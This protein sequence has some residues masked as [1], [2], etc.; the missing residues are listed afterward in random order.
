MT[1]LEALA[2]VC[3][4]YGKSIKIFVHIIERRTVT[5]A[6]NPTITFDRNM[7]D[8]TYVISLQRSF[9]KTINIWLKSQGN[10]GFFFYFRLA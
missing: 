3:N 1:I 7:N 6:G 4:G 8:V 10:N 9:I 2:L 5:Y